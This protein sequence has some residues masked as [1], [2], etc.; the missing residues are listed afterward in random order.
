MT[1]DAKLR[2]EAF[3]KKVA[4]LFTRNW[5]LKL[6]ALALA[7]I[8]YHALKPKQ[9]EWQVQDIHDRTLNQY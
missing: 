7:L 6:L 2:G 8:I 1:G 4:G 3:F 5:G 9:A